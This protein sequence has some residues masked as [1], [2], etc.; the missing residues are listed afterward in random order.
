MDRLITLNGQVQ[1]VVA[2][3][4]LGDTLIIHASSVIVAAGSYTENPEMVKELN[5]V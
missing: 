1:G 4:K 3:N 5:L 2:R